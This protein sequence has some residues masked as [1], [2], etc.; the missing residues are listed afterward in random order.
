MM[1]WTSLYRAP[2]LDMGA[3]CAGYPSHTSPRHGSSLYKARLALPPSARDIRWPSVETC[4]K[5]FTSGIQHPPTPNSA[6]IR[7][8]LKHI[9]SAQAG[10]THPT[11]MFSHVT[12]R[13]TNDQCRR[14]CLFCS[15]KSSLLYSTYISII[16]IIEMIT[17]N[18]QMLQ[19][20]FTGDPS[21]LVLI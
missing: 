7:W 13:Y 3:L 15:A 20:K 11:G 4:S 10:G 12:C 8:L 5:L 18:V 19:R 1:H 21:L 17:Q 9:W 2:T 14:I 6:D 16:K